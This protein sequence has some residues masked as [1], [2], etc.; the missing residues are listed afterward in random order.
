MSNA[1]L[2]PE[3]LRH[4]FLGLTALIEETAHRQVVP[5]FNGTG[6]PRGHWTSDDTTEQA[7]AA[8]ACTACPVL[9][10]CRS[11]GSDHPKEAGVYG[12]TER[13]RTKAAR[14]TKREAGR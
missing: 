1:P 10:Q 2:M 8:K 4:D 6:I 3:A 9:T 11:Y 14:E 13:E 5:C 7:A 12:M